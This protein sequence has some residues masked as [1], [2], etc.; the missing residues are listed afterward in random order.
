MPS[1]RAPFRHPMFRRYFAG[2]AISQV[3]DFVFFVALPWQVLVLTGSAAELGGVYSTYFAAQLILLLAGGVLTDRVSR[4]ALVVLSDVLQGILVGIVALLA[5]TGSLAIGHLYVFGA[6]F[7]AAQAFAMP[8]LSAFLPETVPKADLQ[9][10]NSVYQGTRTL[11]FI[12]GPALGALLIAIGG[13]A[14][15]FAFDAV[16]FAVSAA[17]LWSVRGGPSTSGPR[18]RKP[19]VLVQVR[20]GWRYTAR[21]PWLWITILLFAIVN[22]AEAGPRGAVLP[23][24]VALDLR[25][26]PTGIGLVL[27][28]MAAGS[29]LGFF[30]PNFLPAIRY[31]GL[32]AY[33]ATALFGASIALMA[34]SPNLIGILALG[35]VHGVA[36]AVFSLMWQTAMM[37]QVRE[38]IRGR[39]FSLDELGSFVLLP[40]SFFVCGVLA[41]LF[42]PRVVLLAGGLI[43]ML[44]ATAGLLYPPAHTFEAPR[45]K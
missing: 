19:P 5:G 45:N 2:Q 10:A 42:G 12:G 35:F 21:V 33:A 3:G 13:T 15:A 34:F 24:F 39:V 14:S 29:L 17:L 22:A 36:V 25:G 27:S 11:A 6:L 16:S 26:G 1:L 4:R 8:A 40:F 20:E 7:G 43:V 37:E 23:A 44:C 30:L 18:E 38:D 32:V 28:T 41:V 9:A 31:R